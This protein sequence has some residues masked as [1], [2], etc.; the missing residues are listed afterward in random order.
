MLHGLQ[1][2]KIRL[3]FVR[4]PHDTCLVIDEIQKIPSLIGEIKIAV[5]N[6]P[7]KGQY[8][9]TGSADYHKLPYA[10]ESLAGHVGFVRV[11][12]FTEGELRGIK[13]HF[14]DSLFRGQI[15]YSCQY[16]DCNKPLIVKL[17]LA[18]GFHEALPLDANG[19][20]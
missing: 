3:F 9:I 7:S 4:R 11:R 1:Q 12:T 17:A 5:D 13:N 10:K 6:D 14:L 19:R 16:D 8:I 20:V 2:S 18:G 15:P